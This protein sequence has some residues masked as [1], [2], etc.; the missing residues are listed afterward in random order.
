MKRKSFKVIF[1]GLSVIIALCLVSFVVYDLVVR[2]FVFDNGHY[3]DNPFD[4]PN[5][6]SNPSDENLPNVDNDDSKDK[7]F[8]ITFEN[9]YYEIENNVITLTKTDLPVVSLSLNFSNIKEIKWDYTLNFEITFKPNV[10]YTVKDTK[11]NFVFENDC[12]MQ[13]KIMV[14]EKNYTQIETF[15]ITAMQT[16]G[17]V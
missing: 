14:K 13:V 7:L 12:E 4:Y 8:K 6:P 3:S 11:V 1:S 10:E 15:Y 5:R 16:D 17:W 9:G 2:N